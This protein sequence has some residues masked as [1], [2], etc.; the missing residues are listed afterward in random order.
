MPNFV[1]LRRRGERNPLKI[2]N[3]SSES[4]EGFRSCSSLSSSSL[5][6]SP[7]SP[8]DL[9]GDVAAARLR[10]HGRRLGGPLEYHH[11]LKPLLVQQVLSRHVVQRGALIDRVDHVQRPN[12]ED[13]VLAVIRT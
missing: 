10:R 7:V 13:A 9:A 12:E 1:L 3:P 8:E 2:P 11:D 5:S 6:H 4:D